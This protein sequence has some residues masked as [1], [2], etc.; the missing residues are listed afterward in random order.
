MSKREG[1]EKNENFSKSK[2]LIV[3]RDGMTSSISATEDVDETK[4]HIFLLQ[5]MGSE[6]L[7]GF[8]GNFLSFRS[9]LALSQTCRYFRHC[10]FKHSE[11]V[12]C[13]MNSLLT[14]CFQLSKKNVEIDDELADNKSEWVDVQWLPLFSGMDQKLYQKYLDTWK[15]NCRNVSKTGVVSGNLKVS[16]HRSAHIFSKGVVDL[17]GYWNQRQDEIIKTQRNQSDLLLL[18]RSHTQK[19]LDENCLLRSDV[20]DVV[21]F[22]NHLKVASHLIHLIKNWSMEESKLDE[23]LLE[24]KTNR[25]NQLKKERGNDTF[26]DH[27]FAFTLT[28]CLD[29]V[30]LTKTRI[31]LSEL[32]VSSKFRC[33][34]KWLMYAVDLR[35]SFYEKEVGTDEK[36][37]RCL[38]LLQNFDIY[39]GNFRSNENKKA[40]FGICFSEIKT[41]RCRAK[42]QHYQL[43]LLEAELSGKRFYFIE[44]EKEKEKPKEKNRKKKSVKG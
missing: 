37:F 34:F 17:M 13:Y 20:P 14:Q 33:L 43:K 7:S 24:W 19:Q 12:R 2:R 35:D 16:S 27:P 15:Q 11:Y 31:S 9:A 41:S 10:F 22:A 18:L 38:A 28:M 25:L 6:R 40:D 4:C 3:S 30:M 39:M 8:M 44:R 29:L 1:F 23:F 5:H 32:L 36:R 26:D 42:S 21:D